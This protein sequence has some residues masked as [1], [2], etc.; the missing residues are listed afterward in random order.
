MSHAVSSTA[1][2]AQNMSFDFVIIGAG[3]AGLPAAIFA[4]RRGAKVLLIDA[5]PVVGGTLH[6]ANGQVSAGGTTLQ[7]AKGIV[8][9]INPE[10][11]AQLSDA[12]AMEQVAQQVTTKLQAVI[13]ALGG[14]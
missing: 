4:S 14:Q 5:A 11:M 9:A 10:L 12:P 1:H 2:A 3:T 8:D 6:L 7:K 13:D